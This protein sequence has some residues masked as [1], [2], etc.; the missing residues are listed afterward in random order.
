M[1]FAAAF[2]STHAFAP[3]ALLTCA[4]GRSLTLPEPV[5]HAIGVIQGGSATL[6]RTAVSIDVTGFRDV[7]DSS[8]SA[9]A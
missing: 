6:M 5:E 8:P 2:L 9:T 7:P 3:I 4:C 1:R